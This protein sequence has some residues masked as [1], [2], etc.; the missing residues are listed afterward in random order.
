[1]FQTTRILTILALISLVWLA[2]CQPAPGDGSEPE[3]LSATAEAGL[4]VQYL[5]IVTSEV[6]A[7][8][9]TLSKIHAV[10]FGAPEPGFGNARIAV[11][12]DG[13]RLGVRAP[14]S[15]DEGAPIVRPYLLVED[16]DVAI[17]SAQATGAEFAM[18]STEIPG[19]GKFA[20]YFQGGLQFGLWEN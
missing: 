3:T 8:C 16:M 15:A 17:A 4:E 9:A 19:H 13:R 1:M 6:D 12:R 2:A 7:T 11:L 10:E 14:L 5:E 18:L 20:I